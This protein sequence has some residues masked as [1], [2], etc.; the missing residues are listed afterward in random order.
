[1]IFSRRPFIFLARIEI[2]SE[3]GKKKTDRQHENT[4]KSWKLT[5][6]HILYWRKVFV[7]IISD[8]HIFKRF[9]VKQINGSV[10][11]ATNSWSSP[12]CLRF[13]VR[14]FLA[15]AAKS[16]IGWR[17]TS[18]WT[19]EFNSAQKLP[20]EVICWQKKMKMSPGTLKKVWVPRSAFF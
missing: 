15:P 7:V 1:M 17:I 2:L 3:K 16:D 20:R 19:S 11:P 10:E 4:F 5:T 18:K 14:H 12:R 9:G 6:D 8:T 13:Y